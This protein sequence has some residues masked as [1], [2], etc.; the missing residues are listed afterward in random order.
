MVGKPVLLNLAVSCR[1]YQQIWH[2]FSFCYLLSVVIVSWTNEDQ[3]NV[4]AV[5]SVLFNIDQQIGDKA[6]VTGVTFVQSTT[7]Q[8][9]NPDFPSKFYNFSD[10][11][12]G[13]VVGPGDTLEMS[14]PITL[15]LAFEVDYE[16]VV[17]ITAIGANGQNCTAMNRLSFTAGGAL[18]SCPGA[19]NPP[20]S[21]SP[22]LGLCD[23]YVCCY[24]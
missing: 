9:G 3:G 14:L 2:Y 18:A 15:N 11:V 10:N 5:E 23:R 7:S 24:S 12:A 13:T 6:T 4:A 8:I 1:A 21:G 20:P 19:S 22:Q 17:T 16:F